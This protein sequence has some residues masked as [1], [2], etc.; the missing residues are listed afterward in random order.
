MTENNNMNVENVNKKIENVKYVEENIDEYLDEDD[1]E[2]REIGIWK[3]PYAMAIIIIAI[4]FSLWLFMNVF[5]GRWF[6]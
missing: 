4:W 3:N 1:I 5:M 6:S 2:Y